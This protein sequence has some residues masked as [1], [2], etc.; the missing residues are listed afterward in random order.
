VLGVAVDN[1]HLG[2][3]TVEVGEVL[4]SQRML[5]SSCEIILP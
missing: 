4:N 3:V 2:Q 1:D 5:Y